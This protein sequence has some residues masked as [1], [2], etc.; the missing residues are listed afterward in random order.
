MALIAVCCCVL[1]GYGAF[2]SR[3]RGALLA[4]LPLVLAISF[5]LIADIDTPAGGTIR[6]APTNL[7]GLAKLLT[8][9]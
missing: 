1:I 5:F 9:Q 6:V 7:Q 3:R 8:A 4:I 2:N